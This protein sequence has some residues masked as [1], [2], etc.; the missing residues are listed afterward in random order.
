M[1]CHAGATQWMLELPTTVAAVAARVPL[2]GSE[3]AHCIPSEKPS[4]Y[5]TTRT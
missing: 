5:A 3:K 4:P 2:A 1:G